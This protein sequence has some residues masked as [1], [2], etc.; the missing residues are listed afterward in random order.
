MSRLLNAFQLENIVQ[1]VSCKL[2]N[3]Y[4]PLVQKGELVTFVCV[5]RGAVVFFTDL[6]R[7]LNFECSTVFL[8][9][10]SY[11]DRCTSSNKVNIIQLLDSEE[12]IKNHHVVL[13]DDIFDSGNT[14]K[15]LY[16]FLQQKKP[17]SIQSCVLVFREIM[18][19][20]KHILQYFEP[21]FKGYILS[22]NKF[23]F[24]YGMDW[25]GGKRHLPNLYATSRK[26]TTLTN[27]K[28]P[29]EERRI[30]QRQNFEN[31][32]YWR[33][34]IDCLFTLCFVWIIIHK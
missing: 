20:Q 22:G 32:S 3:F 5:L 25:K 33:L 16:N 19:H 29:E 34:L 27:F 18:R 17:L 9:S 6:I 7:K 1:D 2:N 11:G 10:S 8:K 28:Y 14:M 13:V 23:L 30:R 24:G 4:K 12:S 31:Y 26:T 15:T 21:R